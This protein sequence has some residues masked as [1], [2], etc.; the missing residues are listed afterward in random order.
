MVAFLL[1]HGIMFTLWSGAM[2]HISFDAKQCISFDK[3]NMSYMPSKFSA[4]EFLSI[5][6]SSIN[7]CNNGAAKRL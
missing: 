1:M 3:H 4:I 7:F 5:V 6:K 2:P